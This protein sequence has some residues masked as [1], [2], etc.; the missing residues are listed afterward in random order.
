MEDQKGPGPKKKILIR[1]SVQTRDASM[2][3]DAKESPT[4]ESEWKLNYSDAEMAERRKGASGELSGTGLKYAS[5]GK[6][7]TPLTEEE[8][9]EATRNLEK[10]PSDQ[11]GYYV[12]KT[13]EYK[14]G[15]PTASA[16]TVI[17]KLS[18]IADESKVT[19][20]ADVK[21]LFEGAYRKKALEKAGLNEE[22]FKALTKQGSEEGKNNLYYSILQQVNAK[23]KNLGDLKAIR[24]SVVVEPTQKIPTPES[25]K[26]VENRI[27]S[28]AI[29]I[30]DSKGKVRQ[31]MKDT[32]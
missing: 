7:L 20:P 15:V 12:D 2:P 32:K 3:E 18:E 11:A 21:S 5:I 25:D 29:L 4:P 1:K 9:K 22:S 24:G 8:Q 17:N 28:A 16:I 13:L 14:G 23:R 30:K 26:V 6:K 19:S 27:D 31:E 10:I